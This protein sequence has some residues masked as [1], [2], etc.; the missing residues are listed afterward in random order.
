MCASILP[1][2]SL[3]PTMDIRLEQTNTSPLVTF[4]PGA[5]HTFQLLFNVAGGNMAPPEG[6]VMTLNLIDV[7][8]AGSVSHTIE[9]GLASHPQTDFNADSFPDFLLY[10]GGSRQTAIVVFE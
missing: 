7:A 6:T 2:P 10:Y 1:S 5:S 9:I 3:P 8:R 4:P